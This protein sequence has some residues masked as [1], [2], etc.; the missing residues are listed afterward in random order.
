MKYVLVMV[1]VSSPMVTPRVEAAEIVS[2]GAV[3]PAIKA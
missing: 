1:S 3:T 2:P